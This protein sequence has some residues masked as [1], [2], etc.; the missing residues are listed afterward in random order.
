M[1]LRHECGPKWTMVISENLKH[2]SLPLRQN[3]GIYGDLCPIKGV[4]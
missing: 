1:L 3:R 4:F 2:V